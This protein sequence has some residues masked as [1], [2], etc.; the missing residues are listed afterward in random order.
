MRSEDK[1]NIPHLGKEKDRK[2][3]SRFKF[4]EIVPGEHF[5]FMLCQYTAGCLQVSPEARKWQHARW[6]VQFPKQLSHQL[7]LTWL[8]S[9][10]IR[11]RTTPTT[12]LF[13]PPKQRIWQISIQ[14]AKH[15]IVTTRKIPKESKQFR[16]LTQHKMLL[17]ISGS[18]MKWKAAFERRRRKTTSKKQL[19]S[20]FVRFHPTCFITHSWS[21]SPFFFHPI[22]Q[23]RG[24][25]GLKTSVQ[26]SYLPRRVLKG[27]MKRPRLGKVANSH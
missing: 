23:G 1:N 3:Y 25:N 20:M 10:C 7:T 16:H 4:H 12:D 14:E 13:T 9:I 5:C 27:R 21:S 15:Y 19:P 22:P 8:G 11:K 26:H 17:V 6:Q 24:N 2:T 18:L